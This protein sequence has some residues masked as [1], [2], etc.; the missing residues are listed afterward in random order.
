MIHDNWTAA[1]LGTLPLIALPG[2]ATVTALKLAFHGADTD[3]D[4]D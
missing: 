1:K 3:T 4:S 2:A